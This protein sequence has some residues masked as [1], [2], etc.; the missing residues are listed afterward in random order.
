MK[1]KQRFTRSWE[2]ESLI[3]FGT[4]HLAKNLDHGEGDDGGEAR[5]APTGNTFKGARI[6]VLNF[7]RSSSGMRRKNAKSEAKSSSLFWTGVG[8]GDGGVL[9]RNKLLA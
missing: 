5:F 4:V 1:S 9:E 8:V 7:A 3:G 6:W 2:D